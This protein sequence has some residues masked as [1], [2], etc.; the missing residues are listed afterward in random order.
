M[1][2]TQ[3]VLDFLVLVGNRGGGDAV[4]GGGDVLGLGEAGKLFLLFLGDFG[5]SFQLGQEREILLVAVEDLLLQVGDVLLATGLTLLQAREAGLKVLVGKFQILEA[6]DRFRSGK[7]RRSERL[8]YFRLVYR[9]ILLLH[10]LCD[11][12]L[13]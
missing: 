6:V 12:Q 7:G 8:A 3:K 5:L 13:G 9:N 2:G 11:T 4:S 1:L 10:L